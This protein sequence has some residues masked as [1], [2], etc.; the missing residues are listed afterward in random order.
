LEEE[1]KYKAPVNKALPSL[2]VVGADD[3]AP[4]Y[5]SSKLSKL[6]AADVAELPA[7]VAELDALVADVEALD[8]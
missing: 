4:K 6:A 5:L 8:A 3:F 7:A 2:S 1:L